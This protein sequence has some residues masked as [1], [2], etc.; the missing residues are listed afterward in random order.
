MEVG[1]VGTGSPNLRD[2]LV[3]LA[4][5]ASGLTEATG[6]VASASPGKDQVG[7]LLQNLASPL[8]G[9]MLALIDRAIFLQDP[10]LLE[11]LLRTAVAGADAQDVPSALAAITKL[12]TVNPE[13]GARLVN[14]EA[15]LL[16][17]RNEVNAVLQHLAVNAKALA[18]H[19]I[20]AASL[21]VA[22]AKP[23]AT[24][25]APF[26]PHDLL[27]IAQRFLESGQ[28]INYVRAGE[29]GHIVLVHYSAPVTELNPP[30]RISAAKSSLSDR[31]MFPPRTRLTLEHLRAIWQR[32]PLLVL[33]AAWFALGLAAGFIHFIGRYTRHQLVNAI[34]LE[35][36][37]VGFLAL[38]VFQ[39]FVTV[40]NSRGP[41]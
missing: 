5:P 8:I 34:A 18:E 1:P 23:G 30:M 39:F 31:P 14:E 27:A 11:A 7:A 26:D 12:V 21:A 33:L 3:R 25:S 15:S 41:S 28:H 20:E 17:I 24:H 10:A 9:D 19:Q 4:A 32:A 13:Q 16:P 35:I 2:P 40:R 6:P 22:T 36:W 37:T 38:V 29:L